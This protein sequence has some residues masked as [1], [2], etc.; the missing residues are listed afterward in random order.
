MAEDPTTQPPDHRQSHH[1]LNRPNINYVMK[2]RQGVAGDWKNHLTPEMMERLHIIANQRWEGSGS[3]NTWIKKPELFSMDK[4]V[5]DENLRSVNVQ[6]LPS[7]TICSLRKHRFCHT[8]RR[9]WKHF[10][11]MYKEH[12]INP[13]MEHYACMVDLLGRSGFLEKAIHFI[14]SMPFKPDPLV[15]RTLLGACQVHGNLELGK[16]AAKMILEQDPNDPASYIL[17]SNLCASTGMWEDVMT[18]RKIMK[19]RNLVKEAGCSWIETENRVHKFHVGDTSHPQAQEIYEELDKLALKIKEMGY[20]PDTDFVLHDVEKEQKEKYLFQHSEK[21]AVGFG[22]INTS[23]P[24]PIRVFKNLR[25][26]G[27]CHTAI[28]YI[29]MATGREI[30]LDEAELTFSTEPRKGRTSFAVTCTDVILRCY[31]YTGPFHVSDIYFPGQH[32]S[33]INDRNPKKFLAT[34]HAC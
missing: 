1:H 26:C 11:S 29:S 21:I 12:G 13:R 17:L 18:I 33:G 3:N 30:I 16:H 28:K 15:W 34:S 24:K 23:K 19:E 8:D 20:V 6:G 9:R 27:D 32:F 22:L 2:F 4:I 7:S 14:N 5:V 10:N 31:M 25:V